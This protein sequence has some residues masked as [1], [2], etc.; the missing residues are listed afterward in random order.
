[1]FLT[2]ALL[3]LFVKLVTMAICWSLAIFIAP[4]G[5]AYLYCHHS[6]EGS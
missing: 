5:L 3:L 2:N 6:K 1:V 4:V